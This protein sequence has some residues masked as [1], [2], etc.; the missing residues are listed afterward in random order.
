[1]SDILTAELMASAPLKFSYPIT[2]EVSI[3]T[4]VTG[5]SRQ[6]ATVSIV[7]GSMQIWSGTMT[8]TAPKLTIPF[9]IVAGSIT[10]EEGGTFMLTIP[11]PLQNGSVVASLTIKSSTSTVPF[12]AFVATWPLSSAS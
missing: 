4:T 6:Y 8:Q 3:D 2:P 5:D 12:N 1:M 10:I 11:T 9:N 7:Y